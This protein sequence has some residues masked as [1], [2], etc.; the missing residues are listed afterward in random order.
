[1]T[2]WSDSR[3]RIEVRH[4]GT[5]ELTDDDRDVRQL[6]PGGM[7]QITEK[8]WFSGRTIEFRADASGRIDRRYLVGNAERPFEP[9]GHKWLDEILPR[10]VRRTGIAAP[11]RVARIFKAQ[12]PNGV[13]EEISR[14]D[15]SFAKRM[16]FTELVRTS[17][18]DSATRVRI[19]NQ[20]GREIDSDFELATLLIETRERLVT[21]EATSRAF[22]D[23]ATSIDSDFELRRVLSS[24]VTAGPM[25]PG[26]LTLLLGTSGSIES[27]FEEATLLIEVSKRQSIEGTVSAAFFKAVSSVGSDFEH[28]RVLTAVVQRPDVSNATLAAALDSSA[29]IES[30]FEQAGLLKAVASG[31]PLDD[32]RVP[33]FRALENVN[34]AFERSGV[35]KEVVKQPR[36]SDDLM[37]SVLQAVGSTGSNFEASQVLQQ[38]ASRHT[39]TGSNRDLY[40]D[41]AGRLGQFEQ[42]QA[43]TALTRAERR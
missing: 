19:L 37:T 1:M 24:A 25:S 14:L 7:L 18:P 36:V 40:I 34:S 17:S 32:L 22:A 20:A 23:A 38:L 12:G 43:L 27:D 16:Y 3:E 8:G 11:Q 42:G 29:S 28:H 4:R 5:I 41:I 6:S 9:E 13:L 31:R 15:G 10:V 39:V 35:L 30:D 26:A 33:F 2:S 21:D